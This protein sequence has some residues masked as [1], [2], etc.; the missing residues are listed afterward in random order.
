VQAR[1]HETIVRAYRDCDGLNEQN[2][3]LQE[4]RSVW[5][6]LQIGRESGDAAQIFNNDDRFRRRQ[7][8]AMI[9]VSVRSLRIDGDW[10]IYFAC[11]N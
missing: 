3:D 2:V 8:S 5:W 6:A 1:T 10:K 4:K 11:G 9:R 7:I